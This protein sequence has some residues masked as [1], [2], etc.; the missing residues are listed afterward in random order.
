MIGRY[1]RWAKRANVVPW[2]EVKNI[3]ATEAGD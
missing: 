1:D 2:D 3:P